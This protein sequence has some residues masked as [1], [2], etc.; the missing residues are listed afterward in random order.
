MNNIDQFNYY[1]AV[2]LS[3]LY[4]SFPVPVDIELSKFHKDQENQDDYFNQIVIACATA[5]FLQDEGFIKSHKIDDY[6]RIAH[7][8][9]TTKGLAALSKT[10]DVIDANK[11]SIG[12]RI[13]IIAKSATNE[14]MKATIATLIKSVLG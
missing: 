3:E 8:V 10:P 7:T 9:L 12:E 1:S 5:R 2:I 11:K 6:G 4:Q 14:S 13:A